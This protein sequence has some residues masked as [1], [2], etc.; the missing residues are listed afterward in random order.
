[1]RT[2]IATGWGYVGTVFV[3]CLVLYATFQ[4]DQDDSQQV[5]SR[6]HHKIIQPLISWN[7]PTY[8]SPWPPVCTVEDIVH[9]DW[10]T[11]REI[12]SMDEL[13][14]SYNFSVSTTASGPSLSIHPFV[15]YCSLS[16]VL[17]LPEYPDALTCPVC[18][19]SAS[20]VS[21]TNAVALGFSIQHG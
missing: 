17:T 4:P 1:M 13:I 2:S 21:R 14:E 15:H 6:W 16:S 20:L 7:S 19:T 12:T 3:L 18:H 5:S 10:H 9:G 11:D 8:A